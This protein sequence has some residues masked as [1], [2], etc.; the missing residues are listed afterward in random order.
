LAEDAASPQTDAAQP[1]EADASAGAL[2]DNV[3]VELKLACDAEALQR[4]RRAAPVTA[5]AKGRSRKQ[6]LET[7][8]YDTPDRALMRRRAALR[9]RRVGGGFVQTYKTEEAAGGIRRGEW[10]MPVSSLQPEPAALAESGAP[11]LADGEAESLSALFATRIERTVRDLATDA[12]GAAAEIEIAFDEGAIEAGEAREPISEVELELKRGAPAALY[13]FA[14][15]LHEIA[16]LH[17]ETRSKAARGYRLAGVGEPPVEKKSEPAFGEGATVEQALD[18]IIR[19]CQSHWLANQAMA[20]E[21]SDPEGVHQGRVALR[22]LRSA[23]GVFRK[24]LPGDRLE[25]L[26]GEAKWLAGELGPARDWDVFLAELFAPVAEAFPDNPDLD[27]LR[28]ASEAMREQG[29]EEARAGIRSPRATTFLLTLGDWLESRGWRDGADEDAIACAESPMRREADRQLK[30]RHKQV[31]KR[32]KG[33]ASLPPEGRHQLRI[34]IKKLRYLSEFC[35]PLYSRKKSKEFL[36]ALKSLQDSLGHLNDVAVASRLMD[37][38]LQAGRDGTIAAGG[39]GEEGL[40]AAAGLVI[41]WH[42]R[43]AVDLEP[44]LQGQWRAFRGAKPFWGG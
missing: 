28:D 44:D 26:R 42:S 23:L 35:Q 40:R 43:G 39:N 24:L 17:V 16:P 30:K 10:N 19:N 3:E 11:P 14:A 38:A 34:A 4:L 2:P 22:R 36:S 15:R 31:L 41:G 20:L 6:S 21:G 1:R 5:S 7:V 27:R 9:V 32:G 37:G 12:D 13:R 25:W 8:Y 29:Y 33:F 18:D